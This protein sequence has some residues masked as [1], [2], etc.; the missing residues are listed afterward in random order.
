VS[1]GWAE[2]WVQAALLAQAERWVQVEPSA[3]APLARVGFP[4]PAELLVQAGLA[5]EAELE[6][7]RCA[8]LPVDEFRYPEPLPVLS[9]LSR[10][11][12][13]CSEYAAAIHSAFAAEW[14]R[15]EPQKHYCLSPEPVSQRVVRV[16]E[17]VEARVS[18]QA[19]ERPA[20]LP[21]A[22]PAGPE[23]M[24]VEPEPFLPAE[25]VRLF[26]VCAWRLMF[27]EVQ[28]AAAH[29]AEQKASEAPAVVFLSK[30]LQHSAEPA[31]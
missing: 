18:E 24:A 3:R 26:A 16:L 21:G 7:S 11:L 17:P 29:A 31:V 4:A 14:C 6:N 1:A 8:R 9:L 27:E 5:A 12:S 10:H 28:Q 2:F 30:V 15:P 13:T 25:A 19:P 20:C 22:A 23:S